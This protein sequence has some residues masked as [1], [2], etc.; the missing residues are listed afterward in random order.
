MISCIE[1]WQRG[2]QS[3][4]VFLRCPTQTHPTNVVRSRQFVANP[5]VSP[6]AGNLIR[7]AMPIRHYLQGHR[8]DA[9]TARLLG[10]AFEMAACGPPAC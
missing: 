10:V 7:S 5:T 1:V 2:R 9:E 3:H 6:C 8:F 4:F